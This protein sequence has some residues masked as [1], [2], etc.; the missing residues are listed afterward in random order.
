[1]YAEFHIDLP[2]EMTSL[3]SWRQFLKCYSV[4]LD[5]IDLDLDLISRKPFLIFR[6]L[7][8]VRLVLKPH[9]IHSKYFSM[10]GFAF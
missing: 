4:S 6:L 2:Y 3:L 10:Y 9:K 7:E 5:Q 8:F 1:M